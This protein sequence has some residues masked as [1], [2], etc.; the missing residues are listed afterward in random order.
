MQIY[1]FYDWDFRNNKDI[2]QSYAEYCDLIQVC[3]ETCETVSF[4]IQKPNLVLTEKLEAYRV[5]PPPNIDV[6]PKT[7]YPDTSDIRYYR[8]CDEI[9]EILLH[10]VS[11]MYEWM[12]GHGFENPEDPV[13]YRKDGSVFLETIIHEGEITLLHQKED[14]DISRIISNAHW[15]KALHRRQFMLD[16]PPDCEILIPNNFDGPIPTVLCGEE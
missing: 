16:I 7:R 3:C 6:F 14:G 10:S 1:K 4:L 8:I 13:F 12:V 5:S 2:E 15:L 9:K 11:N